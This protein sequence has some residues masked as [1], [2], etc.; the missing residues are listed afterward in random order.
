MQ[1]DTP[2][3]TDAV[4]TAYALWR[5]RLQHYLQLARS[6]APSQRMRHAAAQVHA[7]AHD[8]LALGADPARQ[9]RADGQN[10]E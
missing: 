1:T 10:Q 3:D 9:H 4:S 8:A 7:A 5:Q 2:I 6:G